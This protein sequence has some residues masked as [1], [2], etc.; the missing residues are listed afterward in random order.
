[1]D[2]DLRDLAMLLVKPGPSGEAFDAGR[3]RLLNQIHGHVRRPAAGSRGGPRARRRRTGWLVGI[4]ALAA[5]AAAVV[6]VGVTVTARAP[7]RTSVRRLAS[8]PTQPAGAQQ[9]LLAAA[10][11]VSRQHPGRYWHF[12]E[13]DSVA[14]QVP[15]PREATWNTYQDWISRSN[16]TVWNW[17]PPCGTIPAGVIRNGPGISPPGGIGNVTFT[18]QALSHL[19]DQP[20]ALYAWLAYHDHF[21]AAGS[22]T[23]APVTSPESAGYHY[24]PMSTA[25]VREQ[26]AATLIS[27]EWELPTPPAVRAAAFRALA[28]FPGLTRLGRAEGGQELLIPFPGQPRYTWIKVIIDPA[29]AQLLSVITSKGT[30]QITIAQWANQLPPIVPLGPKNGC[31]R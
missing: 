22:S 18:W 28:T 26:V 17:Q 3:R 21:V 15:P 27:L 30:S 23:P 11:T 14:T 24:V 7:G 2:D 16:Q 19:P 25:T 20:A 9:I 8:A 5:A 12:E 1:M 29:T 10:V 6:A 31:D 4:I 13:R